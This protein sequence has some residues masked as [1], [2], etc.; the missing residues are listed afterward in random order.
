MYSSLL[1]AATL[2]AAAMSTSAFS[3]SAPKPENC[4]SVVLADIEFLKGID[5]SDGKIDLQKSLT[6][7]EKCYWSGTAPFCAGSCMPG[8]NTCA[9][10]Q[11][12]DGECCSFATLKAFCCTGPCPKN[13]TSRQ[14]I[15]ILIFATRT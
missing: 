15:S 3:K 14:E 12:G 10:D 9:W 7:Q 8:E 13:G 6:P 1:K 2:L 4:Q 11:C 5:T